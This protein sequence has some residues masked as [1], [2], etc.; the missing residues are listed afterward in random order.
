MAFL[1]LLICCGQWFW[2]VSVLVSK[3][4]ETR[5]RFTDHHDM[6]VAVKM[7]LN[8]NTS[9]TEQ[10]TILRRKKQINCY[11]KYFCPKLSR[12]MSC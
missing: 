4:Q 8:S 9:K 1:A 5:R 3:C 10:Q 12:S 6:T 2:K 7:V 11:S